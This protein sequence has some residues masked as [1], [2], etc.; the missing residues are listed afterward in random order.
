VRMSPPSDRPTLLL[1][2]LALV[3]WVAL[4][5]LLLFGGMDTVAPLDPQRLLFYGLALV[6]PIL[7]LVPIERATGLLGLTVE[8]SV[9]LALLL[10]ML[11]IVP[12]PRAGLLA[13]SELPIYGLMLLALF[14]SVSALVRPLIYQANLRFWPVRALPTN[15]RRVRR[16]SYAVGLLPVAIATLAALRVF[17]WI[18]LLLVLVILVI[19]ELLFSIWAPTE[20]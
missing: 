9:G 1:I 5:A 19:I 15:S 4:L 13:L 16:Q 7:T 14:L 18:S 10:A 11:A 6:A 3:C 8:G 17:T 12:A 20:A 2:T